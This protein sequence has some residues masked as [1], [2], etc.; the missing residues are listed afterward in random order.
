[1][2]IQFQYLYFALGLAAIPVLVLLYLLLLRWKRKV[3][4][5]IG[6]PALVSE[7]TRS[8]SPGRFHVKF[9]LIL[10]AIAA[11]VAALMNP[12]EPGAG[13]GGVR[14]GIDLV[15]ALDVSR[16]MLAQDLQPSRLDRAKQFITRLMEAQPNDRV[17]LVFFA[18]KAYQQL[19]LT[20]DHQAAEMF[21]LSANP[22]AIPQQ[23]TVIKEA[24]DMS[25]R[26]FSTTDRKYK[27]VVL[28]SDGEDHD[29]SA[30]STA[31][32]LAEQ[33]LL[34]NTVGIGSPEG[35]NITDPTTGQPKLDET[36]APVVSR[37]NEETLKAVAE[38]S[39]GVYVRLQNSDEAVRAIQGGLS[40]IESRAYGDP[41][42]M[43]F[44]T[45]Y[46]I[47]AGL[48]LILL[49]LEFFIPEKRKFAA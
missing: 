10:L 34:I 37:L 26:A 40:Q 30:V 9:F 28:I 14:K 19:P 11:G 27:A 49:L 1:M 41:S 33:G 17:A 3:A 2:K 5:R 38:N 13:D 18:G 8:F 16:S 46:W 4:A 31:R 45:Y 23:G 39:H 22:D 36:G 15:I 7:L 47:L 42:M 20:T 6:D 44:K 35:A 29:E 25:A 32:K 43:N 21:V 24:L 12:R 48:M